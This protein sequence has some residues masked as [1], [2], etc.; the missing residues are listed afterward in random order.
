M[1]ASNEKSRMGTLLIGIRRLLVS[2][3]SSLDTDPLL[4][5]PLFLCAVPPQ[6]I[7]TISSYVVNTLI[8]A[9]VS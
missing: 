6:A 7:A 2:Q 1:G 4:S 8:D 5:S 3:E 9:V